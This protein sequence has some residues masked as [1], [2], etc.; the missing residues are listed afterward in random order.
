MVTWL[1]G[2]WWLGD[3]QP[4]AEIQWV[5]I[6]NSLA[7]LLLERHHVSEVHNKKDTVQRQEH[8]MLSFPA[9]NSLLLVTAAAFFLP[10]SSPWPSFRPLLFT[11]ALAAGGAATPVAKPTLVVGA[12]GKV[13]RRV[14]QKLMSAGVPVRGK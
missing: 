10:S 12:T 5:V 6:S 7:T 11:S 9:A 4:L 8:K 13:G 3:A 2:C 14:V 1:V